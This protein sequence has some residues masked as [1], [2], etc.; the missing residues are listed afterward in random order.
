MKRLLLL[1][2]ALARCANATPEAI[3]YNAITNFE[4][5]PSTYVHNVDITTGNYCES[6][7]DLVVPGAEPLVVQRF[8]SSANVNANI[9]GNGICGAVWF[10]NY[11]G[12]LAAFPSNDN[13]MKKV[14]LKETNG[15][16]C[17]FQGKVDFQLNC[18]KMHID[19]AS[20]KH[21]HTNCGKGIIGG[22]TNIKNIRAFY[23]TPA[24]ELD[25][26]V[27]ARVVYGS[28]KVLEFLDN[29]EIK[30]LLPD[31][32]S[33]VF[34]YDDK[35]KL[36][37][38]KS[39]NSSGK[40][41][42]S[43][44]YPTPEFNN[45]KSVEWEITSND[46]RF[47]KYRLK[48]SSKGYLLEE[49]ISSDA[50]KVR[51][52][53]EDW[54]H[55]AVIKKVEYPDDRYVQIEYTHS[56]SSIVKKLYAPVGTDDR[57]I[58][59]H[60]F[61]YDDDTKDRKIVDVKDAE[62]NLTKYECHLGRVESITRFQGAT[63]VLNIEKCYWGEIDTPD[64]TNLIT[65]TIQNPNNQ[66][67]LC[68]HMKYDSNG[69]VL[70]ELLYGNLTGKNPDKYVTVDE[71]GQPKV[72]GADCYR[73][74]YTYTNDG[75]NLVSSEKDLRSKI[76]YS[77][78]PKRD[79]I[80]S[81]LI[82]DKDQIV[83][84][85]F[86]EYDVNGVMICEIQDNGS[87]EDS[88]DLSG[89][90]ERHIKRIKVR[91][92]QAPI[93]APDE[94]ELKYLDLTTGYERLLHRTIN[95]YTL[96]GRLKEQHH[97][98]SENGY[99]YSLYWEYDS[100]G[101]VIRETDA[102]GYV[103]ERKYDANGN[104]I[105]EQ[106]PRSD[107][108][109]EYKYDY[110]NR[111]IAKEEVLAD[112][113]RLGEHYKYNVLNQKV[114]ATNIYGNETTFSYD[115]LGHLVSTTYAPT[116]SETGQIVQTV[117]KAT[118]DALGNP[119]TKTDG[120]GMVTESL[121]TARGKPY[122]IRFPDCTIEKNEY[123]LDGLL[124]K[125]INAHGLVT[126]YEYD[127]QGRVLKQ[128]AFSENGELLSKHT[129]VYNTFHLLSEV[130]ANGNQ[131]NYFYDG[132]GRL[133]RTLKG[134][135]C[136]QTD[137]D[138][139]GR[140]ARN[141]VYDETHPENAIVTLFKYDILN[142]VV[143]ET[144]EDYQGKI[145][146]KTEYV[147][148]EVGNRSQT[149]TYCEAGKAI[150]HCVYNPL[151]Q[152]VKA[153]DP[154]GN[155]TLIR[156]DYQFMNEQGHHVAFKETIDPNGN[157]TQEICDTLGRLAQII[158]KNKFGKVTQKQ[159]I[160]YDKN[161]NQKLVEH[162]VMA[163]NLLDRSVVTTWNYDSCNRVTSITDAVSTPEQKQTLF[164]Y[165]EK[166]QKETIIKPDG[167]KLKHLYDSLGRLKDISS[168]DN[169][170]HYTYH[171]DSKGN[172][173][174]V[175]DLINQTVNLRNYDHSD[176]IIQ[177]T[178]DTGLTL[179]YEIDAHGR[180]SKVIS[181]DKSEIHY[182]YEGMRLK[183]IARYDMNCVKHYQHVYL[184]YDLSGHVLQAQLP[185]AVGKINISYD[186]CGRTTAI[187][188]FGWTEEIP[189]GGYDKSGNLLK[190]KTSD[191]LG[192][193][194][195]QFTYDD[196]YQ[197]KS[198]KGVSQHKYIYDS[199]YNR[200]E[201]DSKK[202]QLNSLNQV[203]SD[204]DKKYT[205]DLNGNLVQIQSSEG[206]MKLSYDALDR[207]VEVKTDKARVRY[208][209]DAYNRRL[210]KTVNDVTERYLFTGE[211]ECGSVDKNGLIT[212]FRVLGLGLGAEIGA[213]VALEL[214]KEVYI[215]IHNHMGNVMALMRLKDGSVSETYRYTAFGEESIYDGAGTKQSVSL[216]PWRFS[217]KRVDSET[218]FV[219][220][221]RRCYDP[222]AG[223]W[224]T[225]DP[226][227]YEAGPNL[228]AYVMNN[229]LVRLDLYGL[230]WVQEGGTWV[231]RRSDHDRSS[232]AHYRSSREIAISERY[233]ASKP[234]RQEFFRSTTQRI[235]EKIREGVSV[236][237]GNGITTPEKTV[238]ERAQMTSTA[239]GGLQTNAFHIKDHGLILDLGHNLIMK[240]GGCTPAVHDLV[241]QMRTFLADSY[242]AGVTD[243]EIFLKVHSNGGRVL[244]KALSHLTKEERG[245][246]TAFTFGSAAI[247]PRG[248]VKEAVNYIA[249][250]D[251]IPWLGDT[252]GMIHATLDHG[253]ADIRYIQPDV[254]LLYR[255]NFE[256]S[257]AHASREVDMFIS[258]QISGKK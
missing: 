3:N 196:L 166:G 227:G 48:R 216:N 210:A 152:L 92:E 5:E 60:R 17:H 135:C 200:T 105:Y 131:T 162:I 86:Y 47:V 46:N 26:R 168:S 34:E 186:L 62:S 159:F 154:E 228:Y 125:N 153:I 109:C 25:M 224:I 202:T 118:Y 58:V 207:L 165:N 148:D 149:I 163:P 185:G 255:H 84:R 7:V 252:G 45:K 239:L 103:T 42:A 74:E 63:N 169:T 161:G 81:K 212:E 50:P 28:G 129:Y 201:K 96:Q 108:H 116:V 21:G 119:L 111:L 232:S 256:T 106:G 67:L 174:R 20:Y 16:V 140:I 31:G 199:L 155:A 234:E 127:Y 247:V 190:V 102:L 33:L 146:K 178:L 107:I 217:S 170:V 133:T 206:Q 39:L 158:R 241:N 237:I 211:N 23:D 2:L 112:G 80:K 236:V 177:E 64:H 254:N 130:D 180:P 72:N 10:T 172:C 123:S 76:T 22:R 215:P 24:D 244:V 40:R 59:I 171:Y 18:Y 198:E 213:S 41:I 49:V 27:H 193:I 147:Y 137:Y 220:F 14:Y 90:T 222:C 141:S 184:E 150:H 128:E 29:Q 97:Y 204:G 37:K 164:K 187:R 173:V 65:R 15:N 95:D 56:H 191:A 245:T 75:L 114:S 8:Y 138:L 13:H 214:N 183:E 143:E 53:W 225:R 12:S 156:Y 52:K 221:G 203:L 248:C 121:C 87:S 93:G 167:T 233:R 235:G 69:N 246:I 250:G 71:K 176:K 257:Y 38:V 85:Y 100:M 35:K 181:P 218:G 104:L 242:K 132:A 54:N 175:E 219:F 4:G 253:Y 251:I 120:K 145:Q 134:T 124:V 240:L 126:Q 195:H 98:D 208:R 66:I 142:R 189:E 73:K 70:K 179:K 43:L 9:N 139:S 243:P 144:L 1:V 94:V 55:G 229:P 36:K 136:V 68:R 115:A 122:L 223:R 160:K 6:V 51:Y 88:Q 230:D 258:K 197:L 113:T 192:S 117:L 19:P 32:N 61:E 82:W 44:N 89:V 57:P 231:M 78:Y 77:Y 249:E 188:H 182:H 91:L 205:Y 157:M 30:N 11:G 110:S 226:K 209:Y 151:G 99:L 238:V 194:N 83:M 101:H 79:W